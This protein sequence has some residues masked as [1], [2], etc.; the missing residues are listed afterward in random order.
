MTIQDKNFM[1][2]CTSKKCKLN[3]V[4]CL[5]RRALTWCVTLAGSVNAARSTSSFRSGLMYWCWTGLSYFSDAK[6][7]THL[8]KAEIFGKSKPDLIINYIEDRQPA[9][10]LELL[11]QSRYRCQPK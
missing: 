10:A 8:L 4:A 1:Y 9:K 7:C 2:E 5:H 11:D 6:N 3:L